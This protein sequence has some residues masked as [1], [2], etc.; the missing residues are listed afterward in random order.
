MPGPKM[1]ASIDV[2]TTKVCSVLARLN[3][4]E[5]LEVLG[6]SSI[7]SKGLWKGEVVNVEEASRSILKS[8]EEVQSTCGIPITSAYVGITGSHVSCVNNRGMV[9]NSRNF[10]YFSSGPVNRTL[11][12]ARDNS[13]TPDTEV[14]HVIPRAYHLDGH[15]RPGN[16]YGVRGHNLELE[17][18]VIT[19]AVK[20]INLLVKSVQNAGIQVKGL[21]LEPLASSQAVLTREEQDVGVI[22]ADIGGGSTDVAA[23]IEGT[24]WDTSVIPVGGNHVTGDLAAWLNTDAQQAEEIKIAYGHAMP[25]QVGPEERVP[26]AD[27]SGPESSPVYRREICDVIKDRVE[28]TLQLIAQRVRAVGMKEGPAG[29][30]V[31]TGG[32]SKLPGIEVLAKQ[33]LDIPARVGRPRLLEGA[34]AK[35]QDPAFATSMGIIIWKLVHEDG[36]SKLDRLGFTN[37]FNKF[38]KRLLSRVEAPENGHFLAHFEPEAQD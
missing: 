3:W 10:R 11:E 26:F 4:N 24:I 22:L 32:T 13:V 21:V 8:V 35:L 7:P 34:P 6:V 33:V 29:G 16:P 25:E 20:R 28:E 27:T 1:V 12:E 37:Y 5:E 18:H 38:S 2:G 9:G 23:F 17:T 31:L 19:G 14:L 36:E 15:R 30:L